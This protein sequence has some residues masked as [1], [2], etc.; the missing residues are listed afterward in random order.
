MG[1]EVMGESQIGYNRYLDKFASILLNTIN[2]I[3]ITG[4]KRFGKTSLA[5]EVLE[6]V[7]K[8]SSERVIT[9]FIDLAKQKSFSDF[10]GSL[11]NNLE[12]SIIEIDAAEMLETRAYS[13]YIERMKSV[14][15]E[16]MTYRDSVGSVFRWVSKQGYRIIL[17]ID[18][19]DAA[20]DLFKETADFEF[21]RDLSSNR[22]IG[23][24]LVLISRRQ[25]YMIEKK[26]FNNSTFHGV[27]QTY[28][29]EGFDESDMTLY[30]SV[31]KEKY[32]IEMESQDKERLIYYCGRSPYLLSMFAFNIVEDYSKDGVF[33]IDSVYRKCEIDIENYYKSI[34]ACLNNDKISVEGAYEEVSTIEKLVGVIVGPKIGIVESDISLL[35]NMGYLYSD[36]E[37]YKS[38]S[39]HFTNAL[40]RVPLSVGTW[41]ALLGTEKKI[42]AMIR[43]QVMINND[44]EYIDYDLWSEIFEHIG[45]TGTLDTYDRFIS[46][47]MQEYKCEV[48]LLDV[49]SLDIAVSILQFY[50]ERWF[51]KFFNHDSW[52]Q[53]E[54]KMRLC[55]KARN[56]MAHGHE[57]FLSAE[58]KSSVNGYC[59]AILQQL[60]KSD[61]CLDHEVELRL[62]SNKI[63]SSV[64]RQYYA[65]EYSRPSP[66]MIGQTVKMV[67][68]EL[69]NRGIRGFSKYNANMFKC[70]IDW[71]RWEVKFPGVQLHEHLGKEFDVRLNGIYQDSFLAD[72]V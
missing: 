42:K 52:N 21:L 27:V 1:P 8:N 72:L 55:A 9:I 51:S 7:K 70:S 18:E 14:P 36:Q 29:I 47:S 59:E 65:N 23:V 56:P 30:Y 2:N 53:W 60:S 4:L 57:E 25:L 13:R 24:S 20:S 68:A 17:A 39:E 19:F 62:E 66:V 63:K 64:R 26:N 58:S 40:R 69:N 71:N 54:Y 49:C 5:K 38:I 43:K 46:N 28:P 44:V 11:V 61:A 15:P 34:F 37:Q 31:L 12:D 3:S 16:S 33:N 50:W 41:D 6:R 22:D 32:G 67:A 45:A 10:L 48:D 35:E